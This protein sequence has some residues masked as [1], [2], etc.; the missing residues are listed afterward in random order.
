MAEWLVLS[1]S[2]HEVLGLNPTGGG[3]Q[4]MTV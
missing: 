3:I 1:T 4:L 2:D